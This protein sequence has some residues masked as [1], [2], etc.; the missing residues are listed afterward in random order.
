MKAI[1]AGIAGKVSVA[2]DSGNIGWG[3]GET[4]EAKGKRE[5][6]TKRQAPRGLKNTV[7]YMYTKSITEG[8]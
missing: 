6:E 5:E 1:S 2:I 7:K 4:E 8:I 3:G